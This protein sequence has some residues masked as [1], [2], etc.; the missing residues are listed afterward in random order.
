[1]EVAD[2]PSLNF[3]APISVTFWAYPNIK[4][5][6]Y[7]TI[8]K[9][10]SDWSTFYDGWRVGLMKDGRI[11][12]NFSD[13]SYPPVLLFTTGRVKLNEWNFIG[14][15]YD[16]TKVRFYID[17]TLDREVAE[18]RAIKPSTKNLYICAPYASQQ[19]LF[20]EVRVY[21]RALSQE[22]IRSL[23][24]GKSITKGLV[25]YFPMNEYSGNK[26]YDNSGF[27]N[28]GVIHT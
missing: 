4:K 8:G 17:G 21:N 9:F 3:D 2:S 23:Y 26:V 25:L 14:V 5:D 20:D 1:V 16:K 13:G 22:E 27:E 11:S 18:T 12:F 7:E 28:H 24:R 6:L 10:A 19:A 15:T